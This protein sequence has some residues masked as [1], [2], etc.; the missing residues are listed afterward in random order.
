MYSRRNVKASKEP[1]ATY[2][3]LLLRGGALL[4][5]IDDYIA[6]WH[7]APEGSVAASQSLEDFLGM[8][9]DEY[10]LWVEHPESLRFIVAARKA[11]QSV[12]VVEETLNRSG[13][14]AR[15]SEQREAHKLLRWLMERG[16]VKESP[17]SW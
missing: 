5:D 12:A 7:D 11:K 8:S 13:V 3:S 6:R 2:M 4:E 16:R 1:Q 10:Q 9:W 17:R 14:A 15:A